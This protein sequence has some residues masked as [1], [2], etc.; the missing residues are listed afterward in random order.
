M[1][2]FIVQYKLIYLF[3]AALLFSITGFCADSTSVRPPQVRLVPKPPLKSYPVASGFF[4]V[5]ISSSNDTVNARKYFGSN[6]GPYQLCELPTVPELVISI[7]SFRVNS[8]NQYS[9]RYAASSVYI[10]SLNFSSNFQ[11]YPNWRVNYV[12][13]GYVVV[14]LL[15][16]TTQ[17]TAR[18]VWTVFCMAPSESGK[19][20]GYPNKTPRP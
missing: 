18:V 14:T 13:S 2:V 12:I 5:V 1:V 11:D 10:D 20:Y 6:F 19:N 16:N 8:T 3:C 7:E 4:D 15:E 17:S 9:Q